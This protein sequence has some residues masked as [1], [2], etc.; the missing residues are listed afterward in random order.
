MK[1]AGPGRLF[2]DIT[3]S[4]MLEERP[5]IACHASSHVGTDTTQAGGSRMQDLARRHVSATIPSTCK[6]L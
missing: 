3:K 5:Q 4:I 1:L 6:L 2:C